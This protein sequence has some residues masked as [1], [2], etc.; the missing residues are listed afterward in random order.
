LLQGKSMMDMAITTTGKNAERVSIIRYLR[1][2]EVNLSD[3]S[4]MLMD[5]DD[6]IKTCMPI[7]EGQG[8][9]RDEKKIIHSDFDSDFNPDSRGCG[10][11]CHG[12]KTCL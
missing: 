10:V 4:T 8:G 12:Y 2:I 9:M 5:A 1:G 6:D 11:L 7:E 3:I